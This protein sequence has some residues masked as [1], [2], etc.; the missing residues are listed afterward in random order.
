MLNN[1]DY[2]VPRYRSPTNFP[3]RGFTY[4]QVAGCCLSLS[5]FLVA[6]GLPSPKRALYLWVVRVFH[7]LGLV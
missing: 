6:A 2:I 4:D 5:S 7:W 1:Y 3:V